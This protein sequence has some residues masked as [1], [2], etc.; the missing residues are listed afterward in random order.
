[1]T[2]FLDGFENDKIKLEL[3]ESLAY[4]LVREIAFKHGLRVIRNTQNGWLM[5]NQYGI[6][7]GK[8]FCTKDGW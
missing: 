6:A 4:P 8:A 2:L 1:M 3:M 7:V 5:G